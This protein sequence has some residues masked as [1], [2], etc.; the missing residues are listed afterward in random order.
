MV[1]KE[2]FQVEVAG[3]THGEGDVVVIL[4]HTIRSLHMDASHAVNG[5]MVGSDG[6]RR[7]L[8]NG[9]HTLDRCGA[10]CQGI[11]I[12]EHMGVKALHQLTIQIDRTQQGIRRLYARV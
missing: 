11:G 4:R 6:L 3:L 12:A 9:V 5:A 10:P 7:Y 8:P 2:V 1:N